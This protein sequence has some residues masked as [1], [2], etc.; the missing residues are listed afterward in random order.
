MAIFRLELSVDTPTHGGFVLTTKR[1][2]HI[3]GTHEYLQEF[4]KEI[5]AKGWSC[6]AVPVSIRSTENIVE[7]F[8]HT[9]ALDNNL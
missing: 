7:A 6:V 9:I 8:E 1:T 2:F 4:F 5:H 3:E